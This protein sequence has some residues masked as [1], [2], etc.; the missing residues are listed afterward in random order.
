VASYQQVFLVIDL[1]AT[2][3]LFAVV[4]ASLRRLDLAHSVYALLAVLVPLA[5]G[6]V[7][8]MM[9]FA[10]CVVPIY[11]VLAMAAKRRWVDRFLIYAM[12]L[13]LALTAF[14]FS[15]WHWAG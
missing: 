11:L 2:L 14:L 7:L 13:F 3:G 10:A 9:R 1:A 4:A 15:H 6:R 12:A 8:S 5:S